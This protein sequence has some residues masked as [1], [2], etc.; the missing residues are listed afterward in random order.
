M[1]FINLLV[2]YLQLFSFCSELSS[3]TIHYFPIIVARDGGN[4]T[5]RCNLLIEVYR[6]FDTV[7]VVL[8][9]NPDDFNVAVFNQL[10]SDILG[11][12]VEVAAIHDNG[13]G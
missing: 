8:R 12:F 9:G 4:L 7:S 10:L 3:R 6:F 5:A 1:C 11:Y 2:L 13:N